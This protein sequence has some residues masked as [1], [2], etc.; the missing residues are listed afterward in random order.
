MDQKSIGE[1][2]KLKQE[3]SQLTIGRF[4]RCIHCSYHLLSVTPTSN[5]FFDIFFNLPNGNKK[6]YVI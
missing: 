1:N 4:Y 6:S 3:N 5:L 2:R